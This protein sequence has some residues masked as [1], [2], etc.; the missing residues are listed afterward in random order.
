MREA[1]GGAPGREESGSGAAAAAGRSRERRPGRLWARYKMEAGGRP[2]QLGCGGGGGGGSPGSSGARARPGP[3]EAAAAPCGAPE[4]A[5]GSRRGGAGAE[6]PLP[7][8]SWLKAAPPSWGEG[9]ARRGRVCSE[10]VA[11]LA[12]LTPGSCFV[13]APPTVLTGP[14]PAPGVAGAGERPWGPTNPTEIVPG[15]RQGG[16]K[17]P[18][19]GEML[20]FSG[21]RRGSP[22]W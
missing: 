20:I 3:E 18:C 15:L 19:L 2:E 9:E 6:R 7:G 13:T 21:Q 4:E 8:Q 14:G 17:L 10:P 22:Y 11:V 12:K 5:F 16:R 1:G